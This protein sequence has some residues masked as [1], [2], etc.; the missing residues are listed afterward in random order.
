MPTLGKGA[1]NE[2][3]HVRLLS[4]HPTLTTSCHRQEAPLQLLRIGR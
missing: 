1:A 2:A 4:D 3:D